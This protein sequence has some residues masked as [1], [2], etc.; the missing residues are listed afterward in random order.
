MNW[1]KALSACISFCNTTIIPSANVCQKNARCRTSEATYKQMQRQFML[2][3]TSVTYNNIL[4]AVANA[5]LQ[6]V[7]QLLLWAVT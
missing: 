2:H 4:A 6:V 5:A 7:H 3:K 1:C